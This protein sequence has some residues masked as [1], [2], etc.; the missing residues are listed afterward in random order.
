MAGIRLKRGTKANL[1]TLAVGETALC[2]DTGELYIGYSSGNLPVS[3]TV[4]ALN[5]DI[6]VDCTDGISKS[7]NGSYVRC[8]DMVTVG[9]TFSVETATSNLT[10]TLAITGLPFTAKYDAYA[11]LAADGTSHDT[12]PVL[13]CIKAG[14][15]QIVLVGAQEISGAPIYSWKTLAAGDVYSTVGF[16]GNFTLTYIA[17][18]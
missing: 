6:P 12:S 9:V 17:A 13:A 5:L 11:A 14:S 15:N 2:T 7:V 16:K 8:G 1:P 3:G 18:E 4:Q 10:G